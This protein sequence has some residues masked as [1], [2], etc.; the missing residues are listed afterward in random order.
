LFNNVDIN[1]IRNDLID[2]NKFDIELKQTHK[3]L[4]FLLNNLKS[5]YKQ[6]MEI[7]TLFLNMNHLNEKFIKNTLNY[8]KKVSCFKKF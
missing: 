6:N 4:D 8:C 2:Q 7:N 5:D 1:D 3:N